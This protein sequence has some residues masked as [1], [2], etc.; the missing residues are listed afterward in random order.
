[1]RF[2]QTAVLLILALTG[3]SLYGSNTIQPA[4]AFTQSGPSRWSAYG[5][6]MNNLIISVYSDFTTMFNAFVSGQ[7]DITDWPIQPANLG[8]GGFCDN[9]ANPDYF[10]TS[11]TSDY[12]IFQLDINHHPSFMGKSLTQTRTT[13]PPNIAS[14]TVDPTPVC[15]TGHGQLNVVLQNQ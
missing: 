1:M 6:Q 13:S 2:I 9:N 8:T 5:P 15:T 11:Q 14:S 10:C 4:H 7:I 12:G 3:A